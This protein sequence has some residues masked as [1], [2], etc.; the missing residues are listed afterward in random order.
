ML[1]LPG[2]AVAD[3]LLALALEVDQEIEQRPLRLLDSLGE[4]PVALRV[5]QALGSFARPQ[6]PRT[7]SLVTHRP[8][9]GPRRRRCSI[10][11]RVE[12]VPARRRDDEEARPSERFRR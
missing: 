6:L 11:H 12:H 7:A 5:E 10:R 8:V 4:A 2:R 9:F 3:D 1:P